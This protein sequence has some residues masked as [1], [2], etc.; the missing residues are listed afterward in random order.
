MQQRNSTQ[1]TYK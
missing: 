1:H